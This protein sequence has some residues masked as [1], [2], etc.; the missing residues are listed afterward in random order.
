VGQNWKSKRPR[1]P[2]Q[3]RSALCVVHSLSRPAEGGGY[4]RL[5]WSYF[6]PN[7]AKVL[8]TCEMASGKKNMSSNM[9]RVGFT[10]EYYLRLDH[11]H[12]FSCLQLEIVAFHANA[13][14][15]CSLLLKYEEI[16]LSD[17]GYWN[18]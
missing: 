2:T 13:F 18:S 15:H 5:A 4:L 12:K 7:C 10:F 6:I 17:L 8:I 1:G 16:T 9:P 11:I 14:S 3:E